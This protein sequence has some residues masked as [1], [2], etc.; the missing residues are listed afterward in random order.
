MAGCERPLSRSLLAVKQTFVCAVRMS[1]FD[2]KRDIESN[3]RQR[4]LPLRFPTSFC[5]LVDNPLPGFGKLL[6]RL[7]HL[8]QL[9]PVLRQ[10]RYQHFSAF[11]CVLQIFF[12]LFHANPVE[13]F[14]QTFRCRLRFLAARPQRS[15]MVIGWF[16]S[17]V[18]FVR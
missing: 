4:L 18:C 7:C 8:L 3:Q 13:I 11:G 5:F 17:K 6:P 14:R 1:A 16:R 9:F 2:S 15:D 10:S 12:D